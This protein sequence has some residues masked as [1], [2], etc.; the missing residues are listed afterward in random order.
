MG[1]LVERPVSISM[2]NIKCCGESVSMYFV[3]H[4]LKDGH[5]PSNF[6]SLTIYWSKVDCQSKLVR[7]GIRDD[8][9][10]T[11][12]SFLCFV[13]RQIRTGHKILSISFCGNASRGGQKARL[14]TRTGTALC[15]GLIFMSPTFIGWSDAEDVRKVSM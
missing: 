15:I 14:L 12:K 9:Q 13:L 10:R 7:A 5:R 2:T 8:Q 6:L 4:S 1:A 3:A 11:P